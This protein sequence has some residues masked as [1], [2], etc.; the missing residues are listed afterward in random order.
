TVSDL[1]INP[2]A[3]VNYKISPYQNIYLSFARVTREPRLKNYYDAAESSGGEVPQFEQ[4]SD[5]S[6]NFDNP[7]VKPETMNDIEIGTSFNSKNVSVS[8]NVF[9]ML[10][11]DEIVANGQVDRFGQ[12]ITGNEIGRA[13][14]RERVWMW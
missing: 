8:L 9:Y 11:N 10:F 14:C 1:F 6:F 5:G 13:S 3:G 12:P 7:L 4:N 2:R